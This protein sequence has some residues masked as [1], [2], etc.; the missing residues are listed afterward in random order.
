MQ[1]LGKGLKE[2][3]RTLSAGLGSLL[4]DGPAISADTLDRLEELLIEADLGVAVTERLMTG[5]KSS[6]ARKEVSDLASLKKK[7]KSYIMVILEKGVKQSIPASHPMVTLFVGVN[8]VGKTTTIGKRA[9]RL[10]EE[11]C[12]VLLAAADTFRAGAGE[13][14]AAWGERVGFEVIRHRP[15]AD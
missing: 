15:G 12:R 6:V 3:R 1:K 8:G 2:T 9:Q 11:G 4:L 14:L 7:L 5:L 10:K 13:Q